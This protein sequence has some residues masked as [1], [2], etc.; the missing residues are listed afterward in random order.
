MAAHGAHGPG[1]HS[2]TEVL[3]PAGRKDAITIVPARA[4]E[5]E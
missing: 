5:R 4:D 1:A 3:R 2:A